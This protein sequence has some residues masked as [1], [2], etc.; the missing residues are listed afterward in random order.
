MNSNPDLSP[1]KCHYFV[2]EA[3]D[4]ILF[5]RRKQVVV[6]TEGCSKFFLLGLLDVAHP[7]VLGQE[8]D[9]LRERILADAY[10]KHIP[11]LQPER[12]KTAIEFHAKDDIPEIKR[13]TKFSEILGN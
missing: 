12:R 10:F 7:I 5:N 11:S 8:L 2:D 6:G 9:D 1:N 4:P 3:G 13:S